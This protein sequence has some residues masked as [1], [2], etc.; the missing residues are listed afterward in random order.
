VTITGR[1]CQRTLAFINRMRREKGLRPL[2]RLPKG[3][4]V[5]SVSCPVA[6][7]IQGFVYS[8]TYKARRMDDE[9]PLPQYV[10][11][12]VSAFDDGRIPELIR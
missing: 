4:Q 1:T 7:G 10:Q 5:D 11:Q 9:L 2:K 12:F 8:E 6:R 3:D